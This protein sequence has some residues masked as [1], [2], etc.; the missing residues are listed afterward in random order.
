MSKVI[1]AGRGG[2]GKSTVVTLLAKV[3][4]ERGRVLVVDTDESNLGLGNMLGI[5]QKS[6][7]LMNCLG[8]K[9]VVRE[10]LL[11]SM[12]D[13]GEKMN[14]FADDLNLDNLPNEC[15]DKNENISYL[16]IGKIERSMEG[17]ACP[18][19]SVARSFL[20]E[21]DVD[22]DEWVI[23]DTEAGV[24]HFGRGLLEGADVILMVVDPTHES[25][26][27][28]ERAKKLAE[29]VNKKYMVVLNKV[30]E[31]TRGFLEKGLTEKGIEVSGAL[32]NSQ[33]ILEANLYGNQLLVDDVKKE[34]ESLIEKIKS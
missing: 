5:E 7:S 9:S 32:S 15:H 22:D 14:L 12:K 18:M 1:V 10:K 20:K 29:E 27:L 17:C 8:G 25:V 23:V 13:D 3:L 2:C 16:R 26:L 21:L 6:M 33:E 19:G 24:E 31:T 28:A 4:G 34:V 30:D 11:A